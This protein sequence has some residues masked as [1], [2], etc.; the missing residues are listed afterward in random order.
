MVRGLVLCASIFAVCV[1]GIVGCTS[2]GGGGCGG[3]CCGGRGNPS[4]PAPLP[5]AVY[6][7]P[8]HP[9]ATSAQPGRCSVCGMDLQLRQ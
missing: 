4:Q 8:M 3:S 9:N 5:N 2:G 7:C 1:L 6:G